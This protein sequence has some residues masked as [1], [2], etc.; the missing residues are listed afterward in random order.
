M[1]GSAS[2]TYSPKC[3]SKVLISGNCWSSGG[4]ISIS[5]TVVRSVPAATDVDMTFYVGAGQ[6]VTIT[7][8]TYITALVSCLEEVV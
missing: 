5:G 3:D 8:S 6:T 7:T 4:Q 1:G 2:L